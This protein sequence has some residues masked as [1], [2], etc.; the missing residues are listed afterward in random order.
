MSAL[1]IIIP[2]PLRY[3]RRVEV[4][5]FP[6]QVFEYSLLQRYNSLYDH[7]VIKILNWIQAGTG[8]VDRLTPGLGAGASLGLAVD[9]PR[10]ATAR[11]KSKQTIP[12]LGQWKVSY[13]PLDSV[14]KVAAKP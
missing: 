12:Q 7:L 6:R 4:S 8:A 2:A 5:A 3:E 1:D 11:G 14:P 10:D 13:V 9:N